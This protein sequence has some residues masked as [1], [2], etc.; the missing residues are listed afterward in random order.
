MR[1]GSE[2]E[3]TCRR[4]LSYAVYYDKV[5]GCFLGKCIG[6]TAGGP[7]EGRKELLDYP[8]NEELLHVALPNDDLDLQ[9]LWLELIEREG[10]HI[11]ARDMAKDFYEKVPYGPGEYA[12]FQKNYARG[13]YPP[14]SGRYNNRYYKNGMGCPIRS[15]IWAC[16]FPGAPKAAQK[17]VEMDGSLDHERDSI[18]AEQFLASLEGELFFHDSLRSAI[19]HSLNKV[20]WTSKLAKVLRDTIGWYDAGYDWKLTRGLILRHYGHAD[21]TNLYQN[22][23][24]VLLALLYGGGDF[25]ETIRIGL[26]CGYDTDCICATAASILGIIRGADKLLNEDGMSDTG[27]KIAVHTKRREGSVA[28][29]ARDVCAVGMSVSKMKEFAKL[30]M[31]QITGCPEYTPISAADRTSPFTVEA[32]YGEYPTISPDRETDLELKI[33]CNLPD[34]DPKKDADF[35]DEEKMEGAENGYRIQMRILAPEELRI[36][37]RLTTLTIRAGETV[38]LSCHV[39]MKAPNHDR[40]PQKNIFTVM[41][42]GEFGQYTDEFGLVGCDVWQRYGPFLANNRDVTHVPPHEGYIPHLE[43]HPGET[44]YDVY[45]EYHLGGIADINTAFVDESEPFWKIPEDGRA[46]CIP[47]R[48]SL[49]EDWFDTAEIQS[50]EG[51]HVDYLLRRIESPEDRDVEIAVGHTAPFKLW[52]N[53]ILIG[54][55]DQTKWWTLENMHYTVKLNRGENTI[56]LKCAQQSDHAEYSIVYR[57]ADGSWRQFADFVSL[58]E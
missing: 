55:S 20:G 12:Y 8:L 9:I 51:P 49:Q 22:M 46:E 40:L 48:I 3:E 43:V 16:I 54:G 28:D 47:E 37:P 58:Y 27:L 7:A 13:I 15:E 35:A 33:T 32:V 44:S 14:L 19:L 56:I 50:Y 17:Y 39:G 24:F 41:L 52:V 11:T 26:A 30:G 53:G 25:R 21:C 5:Y 18:D 45:R 6:G 10:I 57:H 29:L 23:G 2:M 31:P 42:E 38:T 34:N 1:A 4:R 36:F